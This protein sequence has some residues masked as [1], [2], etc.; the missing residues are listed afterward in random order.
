MQTEF[1]ERKLRIMFLH[2]MRGSP[3]GE[4]ASYLRE[5]HEAYV[6][7]LDSSALCRLE[8]SNPHR[9][10]DLID[11]LDIDMAL[12]RPLRQAREA[13]ELFE[14]DLIIGS[15][16]G[17]AILAKMV[18]ERVWSGPCI[19]VASA[20]RLLAGIHHLPENVTSQ[21]YWIHGSRDDL[22]PVADSIAAAGHGGGAVEIIDDDHRMQRVIE[23]GSLDHAIGE[24]M[25]IM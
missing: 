17:G 3:T 4:K 8:E 25:G 22:I 18:E 7:L 2:G 11:Q 19:F 6:P 10:W 13:L 16:M 5:M 1:R 12:E 21:S 15:S 23:L 20:A 24:V 14:P 9:C